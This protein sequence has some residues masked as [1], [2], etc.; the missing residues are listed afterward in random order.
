MRQALYHVSQLS[1][2]AL[3]FLLY[4][5]VCVCVC[6]CVCVCVCV[7]A[8]VSSY[9]NELL[10][11][12]YKFVQLVKKCW[13]LSHFRNFQCVIRGYAIATIS[14]SFI[15]MCISMYVIYF[16]LKPYFY[17]HLYLFVLLRVTDLLTCCLHM[18]ECDLVCCD[19]TT[20]YF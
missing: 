10:R 12:R 14:L 1:S 13:C 18:E 20:L 15:C 4:I 16:Y 19:A 9:R 5:C 6:L 7:C 11:F 2:I 17:P 3:F 8:C